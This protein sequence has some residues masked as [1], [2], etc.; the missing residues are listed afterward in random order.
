MT[1]SP[2][3]PRGAQALR[4]SLSSAVYTKEYVERVKPSHRPPENLSD[5]VALRTIQLLRKGFDLATG[6]GADMDEKKWLRRFIF[7]ETIAGVPGM[8][9]GMVR[10]LRS[11]RLMRRDHGWIHT[12][13]EEAENERMHLSESPVACSASLPRTLTCRARPHP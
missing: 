4:H 8:M 1:V 3:E 2:C 13:L 11:L 5:R 10:H 6:Y 9:A 12:L 7:L